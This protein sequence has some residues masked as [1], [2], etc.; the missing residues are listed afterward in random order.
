MMADIEKELGV[1][2][3]TAI[4]PQRPVKAKPPAL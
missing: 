2:R 1:S 4:E 3:L